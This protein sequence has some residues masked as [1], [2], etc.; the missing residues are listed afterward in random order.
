M[1]FRASAVLSPNLDANA[2]VWSVHVYPL[3]D[4][5]ALAFLLKSIFKNASKSHLNFALASGSGFGGWN[6]FRACALV[7]L[8]FSVQGP[9]RSRIAVPI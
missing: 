1:K 8:C 7:L 5:L 9:P 3:W 4:I 2:S 6:F